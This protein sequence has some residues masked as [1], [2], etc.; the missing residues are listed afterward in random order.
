MDD[1]FPRSL[2]DF[3]IQPG[4]RLTGR[5][6]GLFVAPERDFVTR[7]VTSLETRFGGIPGDFH[8]GPTRRSTGREP[9]YPHGTEICNDRQVS[10]VAPD[11]LAEIAR[12]MEL[13]D[14]R[15]EWLGANLMID[16]VPHL[17]MLPAG[18]LMFFAGGVTLKVDAQN[19]P[20]K[21]A[22]RAVGKHASLPDITAGSLLFT[23]VAKRL[24]GIVAWVEKPGTIQA[25]ETV[26]LRLPEQWIY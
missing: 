23:T 16:G 22:G 21:A 17:S 9:W 7:Q 12:R 18:T 19:H 26:S 6:A 24:R 20:C 2:H 11:E 10:I 25:G 5:V 15:P 4:K 8:G 13:P 14:L 1:L 3:S